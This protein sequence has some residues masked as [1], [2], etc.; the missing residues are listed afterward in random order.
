MAM[1]GAASQEQ[2][3]RVAVAQWRQETNTFNPN[4]TTLADFRRFGLERDPEAVRATYQD[5]DELG[6]F[7]RVLDADGGVEVVPLLRAAAW[8]GGLL[9]D[10]AYRRLLEYLIE[11][12]SAALP[13]DAVLLSL[14]GATAAEATSD[15]AGSVIQAVRQ[16]IGSVTRLGVTLDL[17]ANLTPA[18]ITGA[19]LVIGY[20]CN[21][22]IDMPDT[23][24]RAAELMLRL[25]RD[26]IRPVTAMRKLPVLLGAERQSTFDGPLGEVS[27]ALRAAEADGRALNA[28]FYA[29][30]PWLDVPL[31]GSAIVVTCDDDAGTADRLADEFADLLWT[32]R[33]ACSM[34]LLPPAEIVARVAAAERGPVVISDAADSTNSGAPGDSTILLRAFLKARTPGPILISLVDPLAA[35]ACGRAGVGAVLTLPVGGK[36]DPRTGPPVTVTGRIRATSDGRYRIS[37]HGGD[38]VPIDAGLS[39]VLELGEVILAITSRTIVGSHPMVYRSLGLDPTRARAV[40]AK[41][42]HGFRH[43]YGPMAA[44]I[45]LADCPGA[46]TGNLRSLRFKQAG[47]ALYPL[48]QLDDWRTAEMIAASLHASS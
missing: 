30:Q 18:M 8:S 46:A 25:L 4:P 20:Q 15:V 39:A 2:Q 43:D 21:P 41:S 40:I 34:E 35:R 27:A 37:G 22:H 29:V 9:E 32:Q 16:V 14:H 48:Q 26:E 45:L 28:N 31:L 10:E 38:N 47:H 7:F 12:L 24:A 42:P 5:V 6:G 1:G 13:L 11:P 19:D 17:H 44:D 36:M 33:D 23:G 3:L